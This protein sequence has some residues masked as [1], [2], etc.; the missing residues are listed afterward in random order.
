MLDVLALP[1][2]VDGL[3]LVAQQNVPGPLQ[4]DVGGLAAGAGPGLD[5]AGYQFV[6]EVQPG[7][8]VSAAVALSRVRREQVPLGRPRTERTRRHHLDAGCQQ[9]V[10]VL[11][12]LRVALAYHQA[13]HRT[14]RNALGDTGVPVL[15]DLARLDQSGHVG[16]DREVHQVG[17]LAVDDGAGLV[18]GCAV[19]RRDGYALALRCGGECG[20]DLAPARF[21][22]GIGDHVQRGFGLLTRL[23][24]DHIAGSATAGGE[25]GGGDRQSHGG[26][27]ACSGTQSGEHCRHRK[28]LS[29]CQKIGRRK[30]RRNGRS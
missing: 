18:T 15:G 14:E 10:P 1:F 28:G 12:V 26:A 6:D 16:L 17:R 19:G 20:N 4:E 22:H 11:D 2:D 30:A 21:G 3:V 7:L 27:Q 9:V 23:V 24:A 8:L 25:H 13:D 29:R 5:V